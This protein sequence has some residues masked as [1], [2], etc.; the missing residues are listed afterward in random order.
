M[1]SLSS[2]SLA[3]LP[4]YSNCVRLFHHFSNLHINIVRGEILGFSCP[5]AQIL[6]EDFSSFVMRELLAMCQ[7]FCSKRAAHENPAIPYTFGDVF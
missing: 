5:F 1:Q 4:Q 7:V 6:M 2:P 3:S